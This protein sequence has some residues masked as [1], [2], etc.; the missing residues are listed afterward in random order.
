VRETALPSREFPT[1]EAA[2]ARFL[3][4]GSSG[5]IDAASFGIAGPVVES[6]TA[7]LGAARVA[8]SLV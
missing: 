3:V 6:R 2:I 7:L 1:F 4:D 8:Q 5:P